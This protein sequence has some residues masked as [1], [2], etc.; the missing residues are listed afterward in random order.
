VRFVIL[1][2]R[3]FNAILRCIS[4]DFTILQNFMTEQRLN[5]GQPN[6]VRRHG[7]VHEP[8]PRLGSYA[9]AE[10]HQTTVS[11]VSG[12]VRTE[13]GGELHSDS[14]RPRETFNAR[15]C[16]PSWG[17]PQLQQIVPAVVALLLIALSGICIVTAR[18]LRP[19]PRVVI[20]SDGT[21]ALNGPRT[22]LLQAAG[23]GE[24][25]DSAKVQ[26]HLSRA[27]Q[28][29]ADAKLLNASAEFKKAYL[30][31]VKDGNHYPGAQL[32]VAAGD[33]I[34]AADLPDG[35]EAALEF[36]SRAQKFYQENDMWPTLELQVI[37]KMESIG[38][39]LSIFERHFQLLEKR[40]YP[41]GQLCSASYSLGVQ[42][43]ARKAGVAAVEKA[44]MQGVPYTKLSKGPEYSF[45]GPD[46]ALADMYHAQRRYSK[47]IELRKE[48]LRHYNEAIADGEGHL[49][50]WAARGYGNLLE[51]LQ[52]T[53]R[54]PELKE[55]SRKFEQ[56]KKLARQ[57]GY[58]QLGDGGTPPHLYDA[59]W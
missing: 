15:S 20:S 42:A 57:K 46:E 8:A 7:F 18:A 3:E 13:S 19:A 14:A 51:A 10:E 26:E 56:L 9:E 33:A 35:T 4:L 59:P 32:A 11:A 49:Y 25:K 21:N 36:F 34:V 23:G 53:G 31:S 58:D 52:K 2:L 24:A 44:W 41:P 29:L 27:H 43:Q 55:A 17:Y 38:A 22:R 54:S 5:S 47:E 40:R 37:E 16:S 48:S 30:L 1:T 12:S 45:P 28:A 6:P 50:G 39:P